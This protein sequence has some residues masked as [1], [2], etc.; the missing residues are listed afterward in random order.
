MNQVP[1]ETPPPGLDPDGLPPLFD[2]GNTMLGVGE[3]AQMIIGKIPTPAGEVG[4]VTIR[5]RTTTLTITLDKAQTADWR[6]TLAQLCDQLS[7]TTLIVPAGAQATAIAQAA[8]NA[9]GSRTTQ[10]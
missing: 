1:R 4:V 10:G 3:P 9:N 5:T 6:D 2:T 8:R 7:G